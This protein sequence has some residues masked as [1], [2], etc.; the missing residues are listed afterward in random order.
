MFSYGPAHSMMRFAQFPASRPHVAHRAGRAAAVIAALSLVVLPA[1][2]SA[3][4][5]HLPQASPYE[6]LKL[7]Q[8]ISLSAGWLAAR[9]DPANVA[10]KA[11]AFGSLRYDIAIGG[12]AAF[13]VRYAIAPS[14]RR[15]LLPT[16]PLATRVYARPKVTTHVADIGLD[17]ALTGKKTWH[18]LSPSLTGGVGMVSD[19]ASADTGAYKFGSKFAFTYGFA[20]RYFLPSGMALRV[21]VTNFT[22][23][24][25][26][27]D[28]YFIKASDSTAVL[29]DTRKR[30]A[31]RGNWGASAGVSFPIFR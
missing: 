15:L 30:S 2:L 3:Q 21:D 16:N 8:N 22:W 17:V 29:S 18:S 6:D 28:R 12:P 13:Y 7:G 23:Q 11:S 27:P 25:Q 20:M 5:G 4:V 31:Y 19:F 9:R 26:Y 10:P 14:E 1:R 24:Y